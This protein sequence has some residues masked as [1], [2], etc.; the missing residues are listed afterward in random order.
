MKLASYPRPKNDNGRGIHWI[1]Y[2]WGQVANEHKHVADRMLDELRAMNIRW[3]AILNGIDQ[4][5]RAHEYLIRKLIGPDPAHPEIMPVIRIGTRF[6]PDALERRRR[7]ERAGMDLGRVREIVGFFRQVGV[8]Y[9]QLYNEPNHIDEWSGRIIPGNADE[10][11]ATLWLDAALATIDAGGL[12]GFPPPAPG[13]SWPGGDDL[14]MLVA[15]ID[16]LDSL[17]TISDRGRL[18]DKMWFGIHNYTVGRP[19]LDIVD[20]SHCFKK[21]VWYQGIIE[22]KLGRQFPLIGGEGGLRMG[23]LPYGD[24]ANEAQV[25]D[26]TREICRYMGSAPEYLFCNCFWLLGSALGG[27]SEE[28]ERA[29]WFREGGDR[30]EVVTAVKRLGEYQ[31]NPQAPEERFLYRNGR[32]L[33]ECHMVRG[34]FLETFRALG[35]L[36]RCGYPTSGLVR[37]GD[38]LV[39]GFENL[40][41]EKTVTGPVRVRGDEP[42]TVKFAIPGVGELLSAQGLAPTDIQRALAEVATLYGNPEE[43]IPG[44]Y[45]VRLPGLGDLR[46]K[47]VINAF[48]VAGGRT[49]YALLE[50]AGLDLARLSA[51]RDSIYTGPA[52]AELPGMTAL[53]IQALM[54]ALP[55]LGSRV[56]AFRIPSV[57]ALLESLGLDD[58]TLTLVLRKVSGTC[59]PL[60]LLTP[61]EYSVTIPKETL[62]P[63]TNPYTNQDIINAFWIAGRQTWGLLNKAGLHLSSLSS[64]RQA[65]YTGASIDMLETLTG[66][67]KAW[68]KAALPD[69]VF[70]AVARGP[71]AAAP[72]QITWIEADPS[73]HAPTRY[74]HKVDLIVLHASG[75]SLKRTLDLARQPGAGIAPHFLV[76]KDGSIRQ[77]VREEYMANQCRHGDHSAERLA[78]IQPNA[79]GIGVTLVNLGQVADDGGHVVW[80]P[81]TAEQYGGLCELLDHLL[82]AHGIP[83]AFPPL[84]P[85]H[86]SPV[87]RLAGFRGILGHGA[88]HSE[89]CS[90]GPLFDWSR[91]NVPF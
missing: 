13:G 83:R 64:D 36:G 5:W 38:R 53:E 82:G 16:K 42:R 41:L 65:T 52:L 10:I 44:N 45:Q 62:P 88:I 20:D 21:F 32:R 15:M 7:G 30:Q 27:G 46:N 85:D 22:G 81:F 76:D 4:D 8:P 89:A 35:G 70:K 73:S 55:P 87:E 91:L 67:E 19:V 25:A 29:S 63:S 26:A 47:D 2:T 23:P 1:P 50:E 14:E 40:T 6:E 39:Q 60:E 43:L 3:V 72:I 59:G 78:R 71:M 58:A 17:A 24:N 69:K 57:Y 86:Y 56:V 77:L 61:G 75:A 49:S 12:P 31:R 80:D 34:E 54:A 66:E 79:R 90:L 33:R 18:L 9:F 74:G 51:D 48:W 84:G 68:V 28:W 11:C 37:E